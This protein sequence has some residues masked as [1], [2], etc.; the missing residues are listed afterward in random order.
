[1]I[2][3]TLYQQCIKAGV[4]FFDEYHVVDLIAA[5]GPLGGGGRA[6]GVV[7]YRIADGEIHT[8]RAPRPSCWPPAGSAG[9]SGSPRTPGA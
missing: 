7:A 8:F 4:R 5:G 1:M 2:L 9:C 6:A 3:Q